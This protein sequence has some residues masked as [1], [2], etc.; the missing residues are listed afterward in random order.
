MAKIV[1]TKD[2]QVK[3]IRETSVAQIAILEEAG[4]IKG[5]VE[6]PKTRK[7]SDNG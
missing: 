3:R 1:F 6:A 5:T 4:W 7:G 2:N